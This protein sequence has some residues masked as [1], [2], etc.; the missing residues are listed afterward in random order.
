MIILKNNAQSVLAVPV[1]EEQTLL[2]LSL[3]DGAIF[4][5]LSLGDHFRC[6]LKDSAGNLE[7]VKVTQRSGDMLTVERGQEGSVARNWQAGTRIQLRMTA[8]TWEEMASYHMQR[9]SDADGTP[10]LPTR[11]SDTTFTLPGDLTALFEQSRAITIHGSD[12]EKVSGYVA[13]AGFDSGF[14]TVAIEGTTLPSSILLLELGLPLGVHP[15]ASNAAPAAHLND[16]NAHAELFTELEAQAS[17]AQHQADAAK[18]AADEVLTIANDAQKTANTAQTLSE[19]ALSTAESAITAANEAKDKS[20]TAQAAATDALTAMTAS[21][22]R[23]LTTSG[24]FTAQKTGPHLIIMVGGGGGGGGLTSGS[25]RFNAGGGGGGIITV[26]NLTKGIGYPYTIGAGGSAGVV[27]DTHNNYPTAVSGGSS[28][29]TTTFNGI[30]VP[31]GGGGTGE[32]GTPG[33]MLATYGGTTTAPIPGNN[34][35]M[36]YYLGG[37]SYILNSYGRGGDGLIYLKRDDPNY[38]PPQPG[39]SG[40][41][42]VIS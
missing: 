3:G 19:T 32:Q 27:T 13:S 11:T 7:F 36:V 30:S 35:G 21:N 22:A 1:S 17:D 23:L 8:K 34:F 15:K 14:T 42:L 16:P 33:N 5:D 2:N 28:G 25:S 38:K 26:Q 9:V 10:L 39:Q 37:T 4:P 40:A 20:S 12:G 31:G 18:S 24:T 29:G 41:I 6:A